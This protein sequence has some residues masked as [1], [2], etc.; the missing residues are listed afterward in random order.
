MTSCSPGANPIVLDRDLILDNTCVGTDTAII[1]PASG[2][3]LVLDNQLVDNSCDI[4]VNIGTSAHPTVAHNSVVGHRLGLLIGLSFG[5]IRSNLVTDNTTGVRFRDNANSGLP[6]YTHN[7]VS[8]NMTD[9][10]GAPGEQN[11][12]NNNIGGAVRLIDLAGRD[13]RLQPSSPAV[14]PGLGERH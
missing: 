1:K 6:N 2:N 4:A 3:T 10:A 9:Y 13:L 11:G 7:L 14:T 5:T 8:Q 12:T